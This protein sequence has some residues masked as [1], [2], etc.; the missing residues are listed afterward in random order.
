MI[1]IEAAIAAFFIMTTTIDNELELLPRKLR[2]KLKHEA[3]LA[4]RFKRLKKSDYT[5][6]EYKPGPGKHFIADI[7]KDTN[8]SSK[9]NLDNVDLSKELDRRSRVS[10]LNNGKFTYQIYLADTLGNRYDIQLIDH[11]G[12]RII[13]GYLLDLVNRSGKS[14]RPDNQR[15]KI[16][17]DDRILYQ[18]GMIA[19]IDRRDLDNRV[20]K[21]HTAINRKKSYK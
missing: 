6:S 8:G 16:V 7:R 4:N 3:L 20:I 15:L 5:R 1:S 14:D 11:K 17:W 12:D 10:R 19:N 13:V 2:K 18:L 9:I 21:L